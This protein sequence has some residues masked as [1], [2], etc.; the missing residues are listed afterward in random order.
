MAA[1]LSSQMKAKKE[2]LGKYVREV[3]R[4]GIK[5]L[6]PDINSSM[7]SFT[8]VGDVIRFGQGAVAKVGHNAIKAIIAARRDG[9][10]TSLWDFISRV[11]TETI[12]KTAVENLVKAGAFDEIT[13]NRARLVAALP[14]FVLTAQ[15]QNR[16]KGQYSLFDPLEAMESV[17]EPDMPDV[18]EEKAS[19]KL[20]HEK[21][22]MGIY[23][24]GHPFDASEEKARK[25]ATCTIEELSC[26]RGSIPAK[27][28]GI[29]LSVTEKFTKAGKPMG[30]MTLEDSDNNIEA[31]VFP[32]DWEI[33]KGQIQTGEV[34]IV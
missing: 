24:S 21:E 31:V 7:E 20:E 28:G 18:E 22:V 6:Q 11:G 29:M 33:L 23:I 25:Y 26:W 4:G 17:E 3:R 16:D 5:V 32:R 2:V 13:P 15:K 10:Y 34:F 30:I 12:G 27:V 9:K 8:A 1:Y 14:G 19:V